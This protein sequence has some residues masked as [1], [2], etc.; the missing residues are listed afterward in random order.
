MSRRSGAVGTL[1][2]RTTTRTTQDSLP[3]KLSIN[4]RRQCAVKKS[5]KE[6]L[7]KR[8]RRLVTFVV[9]VVSRNLKMIDDRL[10]EFEDG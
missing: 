2:M 8:K 7:V 1:R 4:A 3:L 6:L 9:G 5:H 10:Y